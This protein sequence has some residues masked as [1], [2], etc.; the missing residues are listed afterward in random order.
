MKSFT[1]PTLLL[2]GAFAAVATAGAQGTGPKSNIPAKLAHQAKITLDS[3]RTI[4]KAQVPK[5]A[6]QSEE[7]E[8]EGGKLIYSFDMQTAGKSGIDEVNVNAMTGKLVGKV[9]HEGAAAEAKEAKAEH[10]ATPKAAP[11]KPN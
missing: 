5:A 10:K 11:K 7:L 3:A 4:A 2:L 6:V 9:A 8:R 1:M